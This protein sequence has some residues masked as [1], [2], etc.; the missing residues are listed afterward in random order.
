MVV[1]G[2]YIYRFGVFFLFNFSLMFKDRVTKFLCI[3]MIVIWVK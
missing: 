2:I 1:A 3:F